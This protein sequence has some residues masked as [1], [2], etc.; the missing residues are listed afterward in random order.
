MNIELAMTLTNRYVC[1]RCWGPLIAVV[2]QGN[3]AVLCGKFASGGCN[4]QGYV[5]RRY[6]EKRRQESVFEMFDVRKNYG[7]LLDRPRLSQKQILVSLG[8]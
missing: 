4:G 3:L 2:I 5:T 6:A 8:F 7:F 1:S